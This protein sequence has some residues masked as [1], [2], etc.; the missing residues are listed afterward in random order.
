MQMCVEVVFSQSNL[1]KYIIT[2]IYKMK[3]YGWQVFCELN[4]SYDLSHKKSEVL[5]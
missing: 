4:P 5:Y 3:F 2:A 1:N